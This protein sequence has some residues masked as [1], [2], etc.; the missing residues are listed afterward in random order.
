MQSYFLHIFYF[1]VFCLLS[2]FEFCLQNNSSNEV[3]K[4]D[5][6]KP[7]ATRRKSLNNI[8]S[9][10]ILFAIDMNALE[11]GHTRSSSVCAGV[12]GALENQQAQPVT[13]SELHASSTTYAKA[14][15]NKLCMQEK[16]QDGSQ[17][18][19]CSGMS[20]AVH[21]LE[22][23]KDSRDARESSNGF[24]ERL[25]LKN[26]VTQSVLVN[27]DGKNEVDAEMD[28]LEQS[29]MT[30]ESAM[31]SKEALDCSLAKN[32]MSINGNDIAFKSDE[33]VS[34]NQVFRCSF[35]SFSLFYISFVGVTSV[36]FYSFLWLTISFIVATCATFLRGIT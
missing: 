28:A 4:N 30:S 19:N 12:N 35:Y 23:E 25:P 34:S 22:A 29:P 21:E 6:T 8:D 10:N 15:E 3:G 13:P 20:L 5:V 17:V 27:G 2:S 31:A 18:A 26:S 14:T 1:F 24:R 33:N 36:I 32:L 16:T 7:L 9:D 11:S